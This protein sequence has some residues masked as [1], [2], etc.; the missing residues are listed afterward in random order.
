M[1][2]KFDKSFNYTNRSEFELD[3]SIELPIGTYVECPKC[4]ESILCN[5]VEGIGETPKGWCINC[6]KVVVISD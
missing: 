1:V 5:R 3:H 4:K 6:K 2:E